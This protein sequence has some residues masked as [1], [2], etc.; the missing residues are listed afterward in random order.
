[1]IG[2]GP[3][4]IPAR[5]CG[6]SD[7]R[8]VLVQTFSDLYEIDM[9]GEAKEK[10]GAE[11]QEDGAPE[12]DDGSEAKGEPA[13]ADGAGEPADEEAEEKKEPTEDEKEQAAVEEEIKEIQASLKE[14][15]AKAETLEKFLEERHKKQL[16]VEHDFSRTI[17]KQWGL[18][19]GVDIP[20]PARIVE[21]S[22]G[23]HYLPVDDGKVDPPQARAGLTQEMAALVPP[24][25]LIDLKEILYGTAAERFE[26]TR[27]RAL[28][29]PPPVG[30]SKQLREMT[31]TRLPPGLERTGSM[32]ERT[33]D[34]TFT[35]H[36][37]DD[38]EYDRSTA[39]AAQTAKEV[40]AKRKKAR[41]KALVRKMP[42]KDMLVEEKR[43]LE[44]MT[45]KLNFLK[46][47]RFSEGGH[48]LSYSTT[49]T[50]PIKHGS[51]GGHTTDALVVTPPGV[52]F[53][54]YEPGRVYTFKVRVTNKTALSRRI[55]ILPTTNKRFW[56]KQ[57]KFP[58][59]QGMLAPGIHIT[60][61]VYFQPDSLSAFNDEFTVWADS[62]AVTVPIRACRP[63]PVLNLT[64]NLVFDVCVIGECASN[65]QTVRNTGG[66]GRFWVFPKV[67][68][69]PAPTMDLV[70]KSGYEHPSTAKVGRFSVTPG[71]FALG[72]G[73]SVSI[74]IEFQSKELSEESQTFY[75]LC[76]N[77]TVTEHKLS[78]KAADLQ[79]ALTG[80]EGLDIKLDP[81]VCSLKA[82]LPRQDGSYPDAL[83]QYPPSSTLIFDGATVGGSSTRGLFL[84][85]MCPIPVPFEWKLPKENR[86]RAS[87]GRK[88]KSLFTV[89]PKRGVIEPFQRMLFEVNFHPRN[90]ALVERAARFTVVKL[91]NSFQS[92]GGASLRAPDPQRVD[93]K[94]NDVTLP[95][96]AF[97]FQGRGEPGEVQV[98]P[99]VLNLGRSV[100]MGS[101]A[102]GTLTIRNVSQS[103]VYWAFRSARPAAGH[104]LGEEFGLRLSNRSDRLDAGAQIDVS[105]DIEF[106]KRPGVL[107][108]D[109]P[110]MANQG[111]TTITRLR[112]TVCGPEIRVLTPW[113]DYGALNFGEAGVNKTL[114]L[115]VENLSE[116]PARFSLCE[117]GS[118]APA[119]GARG[120]SESG[121]TPK[122]L[123]FSE[124]TGTLKAREKRTVKVTLYPRALGYLRSHLEV[125]VEHGSTQYAEVLCK[126]EAPEFEIP[127]VTRDLGTCY[128]GIPRTTSFVVRNKTYLSGT[129]QW[130]QQDYA[131]YRAEYS[132]GLG[133]LGAK[134]ENAI[135]VTVL[136]KTPGPLRVLTGC[137]VEG[138]DEPLG[139]EI[140]GTVLPL[141]VSIHPMNPDDPEAP[142]NAGRIGDDPIQSLAKRRAAR[143]EFRGKSSEEQEQ[144]MRMRKLDAL[145]PQKNDKEGAGAPAARSGLQ[146][147]DFGSSVAIFSQQERWIV[148]RNHTA[149][150]TSFNVEMEELSMVDTLPEYNVG[151]S[152][153][154]T[155][156]GGA[157]S[158]T[159]AL[160]MT[161]L[162][163]KH[164][165]ANQYRSKQGQT[166]IQ[167]FVVTQR[168]NE[169]LRRAS[170]IAFSITPQRGEL[171]PFEVR[172][173]RVACI[174]N[175]CGDFSDNLRVE[176]KGLPVRR[177]P[178]RMR[179]TGSPVAFCRD[180]AGVR[181]EQG[182]LNAT[183]WWADVPE[184]TGA[185]AKSVSL[186]NRGPV[187]VQ[188]R[189][190]MH[191]YKKVNTKDIVNVQIEKNGGG[192]DAVSV[193]LKPY[194]HPEVPS[195]D[196][197]AFRVKESS[198]V[199]PSQGKAR[200]FVDFDS[201]A[202]TCEQSAA[203]LQARL[204]VKRSDA[205]TLLRGQPAPA[206]DAAGEDDAA[207]D[208]EESGGGDVKMDVKVN[209]DDAFASSDDEDDGRMAG[210]LGD[211]DNFEK[212]LQ[213]VQERRERKTKA[214][215]D[216]AGDDSDDQEMAEA[217]E[218]SRKRRFEKTERKRRREA[219]RAAE[220]SLGAPEWIPAPA[221]LDTTMLILAL[222]ARAIE[223]SLQVDKRRAPDGK[224]SLKFVA[225]PYRSTTS[226][227]ETPMVKTIPVAN[228]GD[229]TL[230]FR[231]KTD[232]AEW[233]R[234]DFV[235]ESASD[236]RRKK[237][238][239]TKTQGAADKFRPSARAYPASRQT[240]LAP[241]ESALIG[242]R[243][244]PAAPSDTK[245]W[246]L[247]RDIVRRG[248]L[249]VDFEDRRDQKFDL[250]G[251]LVRPML[252]LNQ[253]PAK[254]AFPPTFDTKPYAHDFSSVR[255]K[256][257]Q[258]T[259]FEIRNPTRVNA[260]WRLVHVPRRKTVKGDSMK[261]STLKG[262]KNA[263]FELERDMVDDPSVFIFA[264]M[265]GIVEALTRTR[266]RGF[267]TQR[268]NTLDTLM[269]SLRKG[270]KLTD[271]RPI[272]MRRDEVEHLQLDVAFQ[273][274][275]KTAY[276]SKFRLEVEA[277]CP[278]GVEIE[279]RGV[280]TYDE[281]K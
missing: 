187:D 260:K 126:V 78:A 239:F 105:V 74:N 50:R 156:N 200:V 33:Q 41:L 162:D 189:W 113:L 258:V 18:M 42:R 6:P 55:K 90:T 125:H 199:I 134:E 58:G 253:T 271:T 93:P 46:N 213:R 122:G 234:V 273:P 142:Q 276:K 235:S 112:A 89:R 135:E 23:K 250:V 24:E 202:A 164:E 131:E 49:K 223:S 210:V 140:T 232:P 117:S 170:G 20:A 262:L 13:A 182:G 241:G 278:S 185:Y 248:A 243:F 240:V 192:D 26:V 266:A 108:I 179:V 19:P 60:I 39:K 201:D 146:E 120:S 181:W 68:G 110:I 275:K 216:G 141:D 8:G 80:L 114:S 133:K 174:N 119:F 27:P 106:P 59:S 22:D 35:V 97:L 231:V 157:Q 263:E 191:D 3:T 121:A 218:A 205:P 61:T 48:T 237:S 63:P 163:A 38:D 40:R 215:A 139:V 197:F 194:T 204:Y 76:D 107:A 5:K 118:A 211:I 208:G 84:S 44:R 16:D 91:P 246:P 176:V 47:P 196:P 224:Q 236:P 100:R 36:M 37:E 166:Y 1:M 69:E 233:F 138:I 264:K 152:S 128:V 247:E 11:A 115:V 279:L 71:S 270:Q 56:L 130:E 245:R 103:A 75:L 148:L 173:V 254:V 269:A 81:E 257:T 87:D 150:P 259:T 98:S 65:P 198:V 221:P 195:D 85:N 274:K 43:V 222:E 124:N 171:G 144:A 154:A 73:D 17:H 2:K 272:N 12:G 169:I 255:L 129:Y 175:L 172:R 238:A 155:A 127:T 228:R 277:G 207:Q 168:R 183:M 252:E 101:T 159:R 226:E 256:T 92:V 153:A 52:E 227:A 180:N 64:D 281:D 219:K 102:T 151:D 217:A 99:A 132:P 28:S 104:S 31:A 160:G 220:S 136:P 70:E 145:Y 229:S 161:R 244:T 111:R 203:F 230:R 212:T 62:G 66:H 94:G 178:V 265:S 4:L 242:V 14:A 193:R 95:L 190:T 109:L 267:P 34:L 9:S 249:V 225:G 206:D 184:N 280:G 188:L 116:G 167:S 186:E 67:D 53:T 143:E 77:H 261:V 268:E 32:N 51:L 177:F 137:D 123:I 165:S 86:K 45:R 149:I 82:A 25:D 251:T 54:R 214:L 72:R 96:M 10:K 209:I 88:L 79:V 7:I 15:R 158:N 57:S 30:T 21:A 29:P 83:P 147:I